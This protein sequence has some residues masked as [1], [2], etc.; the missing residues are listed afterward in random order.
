MMSW[1]LIL[2]GLFIEVTRFGSEDLIADVLM[3]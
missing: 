3:C 1:W 2:K